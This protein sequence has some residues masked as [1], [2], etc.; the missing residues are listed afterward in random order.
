MSSDMENEGH[1]GFPALSHTERTRH[2]RLRAQGRTDRAE[3]DAIPS[4]GFVCH[5]GTLVDGVPM[6]VPTVYGVEDGIMYVHGS[7]GSRSM[8]QAVGRTVCATVTHVDGL[9]LA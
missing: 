4:G 8:Q 7:V 2:R 6:V 1:R 3:L 9:V 5:L